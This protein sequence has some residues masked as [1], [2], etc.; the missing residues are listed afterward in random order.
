MIHPIVRMYD[1]ADKA[2]AAVAKLKGWGLTSDL[3]SVISVAAAGSADALQKAL[4]SA[5]IVRDHATIYARSAAAGST[6]VVVRAPFGVGVVTGDILDSCHPISKSDP[7]DISDGPTWDDAAPL[8][9][10][11]HLP[12]ISQWRPFGGMPA[13]GGST[14]TLCSRLGIP[15]LSASSAPTTEGMMKLLSDSKT[16]FSSMLNL[17]LLR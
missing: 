5:N 13:G 7:T 15:E 11:L 2:S 14:R 8:S 12:V 6:I 4:M 17:P 1:T 10:A 3:I 9:S 16:P